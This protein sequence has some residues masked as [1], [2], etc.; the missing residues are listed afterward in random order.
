MTAIPSPSNTPTDTEGGDDAMTGPTPRDYADLLTAALRTTGQHSTADLLEQAAHTRDT[1]EQDRAR[2]ALLTSG[3][4]YLEQ[5]GAF[6]VR[7]PFGRW[8]APAEILN[9]AAQGRLR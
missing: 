8:M 6:F 4:S 1:A 3:L 5:E 9:A 7:G 2:R